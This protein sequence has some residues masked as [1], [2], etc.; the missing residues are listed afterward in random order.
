MRIDRPFDFLRHE[1]I[2]QLFGGEIHAHAWY[3]E[4]P[5]APFRQRNE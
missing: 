1:R 4:P 3:V 5:T 2:A